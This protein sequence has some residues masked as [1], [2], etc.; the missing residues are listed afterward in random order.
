MVH[1]IACFTLIYMYNSSKPGACRP[2][3]FATNPVLRSFTRKKFFI[4]FVILV[5]HY[6]E[7]AI[8]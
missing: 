3:S 5:P 7:E 8:S 4:Q 1:C 6:S 2:L